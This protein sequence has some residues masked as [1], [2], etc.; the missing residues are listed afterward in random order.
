[1]APQLLL[2]LLL[3]LG[4]HDFPN[5]VFMSIRFQL[6]WLHPISYYYHQVTA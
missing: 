1:M 4:D 3:L 6:V 5:L 2:V